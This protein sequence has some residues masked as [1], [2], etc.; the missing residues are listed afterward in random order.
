MYM[1]SQGKTE[2][3]TLS[4]LVKRFSILHAIFPKHF[5]LFYGFFFALCRI[6]MAKNETGK[7]YLL[8]QEEKY[9]V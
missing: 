5:M 2:T 4:I 8:L 9:K 3:K 7:S 1:S 6:F